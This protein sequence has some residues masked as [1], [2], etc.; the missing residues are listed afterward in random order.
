VTPEREPFGA[1]DFGHSK[2]DLAFMVV[3]RTRTI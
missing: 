3:C 2:I 1:S